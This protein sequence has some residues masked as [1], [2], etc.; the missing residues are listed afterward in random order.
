M[1]K[2]ICTRCGESSERL[3]IL[4]MLKAFGAHVSGP[5]ETCLENHEHDFQPSMPLVPDTLAALTQEDSGT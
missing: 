3:L 4:A 5:V 2:L 1:T